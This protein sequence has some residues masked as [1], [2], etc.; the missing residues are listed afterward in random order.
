MKLIAVIPHINISAA[1]FITLLLNLYSDRLDPLVK[2]FF[3]I[4]NTVNEY[5]ELLYDIYV[6]EGHFVM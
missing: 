5:N 6:Y 4:P 1:S 2:E 3:L